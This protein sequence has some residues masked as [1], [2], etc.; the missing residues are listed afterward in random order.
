MKVTSMRASFPHSWRSLV[1]LL[2]RKPNTVRPLYRKLLSF[3][4]VSLRVNGFSSGKCASLPRLILVMPA[5]NAASERSFSSMRRLK[6]YLW[7]TMGQA[8]LNH[9]MLLNTYKEMLDR[10]DVNVI[11]NEFVRGSEHRLSLFGK[12][13]RILSCR[14]FSLLEISIRHHLWIFLLSIIFCVYIVM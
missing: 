8:R 12:L 1:H 4:E 3:C 11:A 13:L 5:T 9:I 10:L 2:P 6:S 14:R 7:S